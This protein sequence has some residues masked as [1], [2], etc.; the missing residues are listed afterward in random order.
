MYHCPFL[1]KMKFTLLYLITLEW[2]V[3]ENLQFIEL[4]FSSS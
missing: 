1:E 2:I 4:M 3:L